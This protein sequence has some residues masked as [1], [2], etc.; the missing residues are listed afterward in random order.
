MY[1]S[2]SM[3]KMECRYAQIEKEALAITWACE[4]FSDYILGKTITIE[5]DHKPLVPL[6]GA[7]RQDSLP[8]RVLSLRLDRFN[9]SINH[10][11]GKQLYTA[12]TLSRAPSSSTENDPNLEELAELL[13][14]THISLPPANKDGLETYCSAQNAES[15]CSLLKRYCRKGWPERDSIDQ[16]VNPYWEV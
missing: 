12:D 11:P 1:A 14:E 10:I 8:P 3:T 15:T 4:K 13:M 2:R 6:L 9:Y 16:V 7:K 5:T